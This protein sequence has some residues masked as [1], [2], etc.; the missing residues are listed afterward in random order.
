MLLGVFVAINDAQ[1]LEVCF[2][3]Q[4]CMVEKLSET[5][6]TN[7]SDDIVSIS[8]NLWGLLGPKFQL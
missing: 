3:K 2:H 4:N 8:I 1:K 7:A 5:Q 6:F